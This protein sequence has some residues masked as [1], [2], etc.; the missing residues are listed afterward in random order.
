MRQ[1]VQKTGRAASTGSGTKSTDRG[2][3][4]KQWQQL[5]IFNTKTLTLD[6][7]YVPGV[8]KDGRGPLR[9]QSVGASEIG[10]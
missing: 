10:A 5:E 8:S 2:T 1:S 6:H 4:R 9:G 3:S 7:F